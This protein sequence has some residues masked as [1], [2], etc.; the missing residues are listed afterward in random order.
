MKPTFRYSSDRFIKKVYS[1]NY[2]SYIYTYISYKIKNEY[3]LSFL[4]ALSAHKTYIC[5]YLYMQRY[6][7]SE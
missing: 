1:K 6:N 5:L 3:L 4:S 7:K 2:L